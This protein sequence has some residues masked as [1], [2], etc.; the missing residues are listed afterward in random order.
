VAN[1]LYVLWYVR[2]RFEKMMVE[3]GGFEGKEGV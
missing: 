3:R 2:E 1:P